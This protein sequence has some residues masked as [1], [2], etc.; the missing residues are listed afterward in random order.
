MKGASASSIYVIKLRLAD[1]DEA[2]FESVS[3]TDTLDDLKYRILTSM[4]PI[5]AA[6]EDIMTVLSCY[7]VK[8]QCSS[9]VRKTV[10]VT[11][12]A[13]EHVIDAIRNC[14]L[15]W[16]GEVTIVLVDIRTSTLF[17]SDSLQ[18]E[19]F[20][21]D[22]ECTVGMKPSS[23]TEWIAHALP[24]DS[25]N[26]GIKTI[27]DSLFWEISNTAIKQGKLMKKIVVSP[28][29]D[30][31]KEEYF[32]LCQNR[33]WYFSTK[34]WDSDKNISFVELSDHAKVNL[35]HPNSTVFTLT[36]TTNARHGPMVLKAKSGEEAEAWV[37][38]LCGR[39][40]NATENDIFASIEAL[41]ESAEQEEAIKDI[42]DLNLMCSF[43]GLLAS[44]DMRERFRNHLYREMMT[45][46]LLFW[47][48]AED[49][50]RGHPCSKQPLENVPEQPY[51]DD[52]GM[53][54][55]AFTKR[56]AENIYYDFLAPHAPHA[57]AHPD[58][59]AEKV[60]D[61]IVSCSFPAPD[62]FEDIQVLAFEELKQNLYPK[63]M[64]QKNY[65]R[66]LAGAI[67]KQKYLDHSGRIKRIRDGS[68]DVGS[69]AGAS[70][71][72][73]EATTADAMGSSPTSTA[74]GTMSMSGNG[75]GTG[76]S[77]GGAGGRNVFGAMMTMGKFVK[78]MEQKA[79]AR[80]A[81]PSKH[82]HEHSPDD[83]RFIVPWRGHRVKEQQQYWLPESWWYH[84]YTRE[85]GRSMD[86]DPHGTW[87]VARPEFDTKDLEFQESWRPWHTITIRE[88]RT[89]MK[90]L[91]EILEARMVEE[92]SI[93]QVLRTNFKG[94]KIKDDTA[95]ESTARAP[96]RVAMARRQTASGSMKRFAQYTQP[97]I[98]HL[99]FGLH[100][101]VVLSG[102]ARCSYHQKHTAA[103]PQF[104]QAGYGV[105]SGY[106]RST[107]ALSGLDGDV[108]GMQYGTS[109]SLSPHNY[110][111]SPPDSDTSPPVSPYQ[112][113]G[114]G[115]ASPVETVGRESAANPHTS[116]AHRSM[117]QSNIRRKT[118]S[119][120][121]R[122][123]IAGS[124]GSSMDAGGRP[125]SSATNRNTGLTAIGE[126]EGESENNDQS[127]E[128]LASTAQNA[129]IGAFGLDMVRYYIVFVEVFG[130]G[131]LLLYD[132]HSHVLLCQIDLSSVVDVS[133]DHK[134]LNGIN[135]KDLGGLAWKICPESVEEEDAKFVWSR[136]VNLVIGYVPNPARA[137][138]IVH[139]G[140]LWKR[141]QINTSFK[142]RWFVLTTDR[143]L[144]YYKDCVNGG[145]K[146]EINLRRVTN[147]YRG[148]EFEQSSGGAALG[149]SSAGSSSMVNWLKSTA[150]GD[151]SKA[152]LQ[153]QIGLWTHGKE[154]G[155]RGQETMWK[156]QG[157]LYIVRTETLE[158]FEVWFS[159]LKMFAQPG[160]NQQLAGGYEEEEVFY[161]DDD[162]ESDGEGDG[163]D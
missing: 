82:V 158:E 35:T 40:D 48:R 50:R 33:L 41:T 139:V 134:T 3:S 154:K 19:N 75:K 91:D 112:G 89:L 21:Q 123:T 96:E 7:I 52:K 147:I 95:D 124:I 47:E 101:L 53:A 140:Y 113:H 159:A 127:E 16:P 99:P 5:T 71:D 39:D 126:G 63:F 116:F 8:I 87:S 156:Q 54:P 51:G 130:I 163:E 111:L 122:R 108:H 94:L 135:L 136:W 34:S 65:Q 56:W 18:E 84:S 14:E 109:G 59:L 152:N 13:H 43:E 30:T 98:A 81:S 25:Q 70:M 67:Y 93:K 148:N 143:K 129:F 73:S 1:E 45:E 138:G 86:T 15:T 17:A 23:C 31:W 155:A 74:R 104:L 125:I 161:D 150:S 10:Y 38:A 149:G 42:E 57:Y 88:T 90:N 78:R 22:E 46:K 117:R 66:V 145:Y 92:I 151:N 60:K 32:M 37:T 121:S 83:N 61:G 157:R 36:F 64:A 115:H 49:Y 128:T 4:A 76:G 26:T 160:N 107:M 120:N 103:T 27:P 102:T 69:D 106:D 105:S 6:P 162:D 77:A 146:G 153:K 55:A 12:A 11:P 72:G 28:T 62:V 9:S 20:L 137:A 132:Y 110:S 79:E 58:S 142:R 44:E 24:T 131:K 141:G 144:L 118:M 114:E 68:L 119:R 133:V 80:R 97:N 29:A 2:K 85:R 100:G